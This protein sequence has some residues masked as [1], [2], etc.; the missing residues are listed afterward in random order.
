VSAV[1]SFYLAMTLFPE[2][3]RAAQAEIDIVVGPDRCVEGTRINDDELIDFLS[4][5]PSFGDRERLP[6]I[7]ALFKEVLRWQPVGPMGSSLARSLSLS[8]F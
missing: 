5:L 1:H 4:S 8:W 3:Q 7:E 2:I 6:Y